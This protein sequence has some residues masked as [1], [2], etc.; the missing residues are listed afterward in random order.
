[1]SGQRG[2]PAGKRPEPRA[3]KKSGQPRR[4]GARNPVRPD[5]PAPPRN[6]DASSRGAGPFH[7][8]LANYVAFAAG[9]VAIVAGYVQL[10]AGSVTAAPFLLILGYAVLLPL[11]LILGWGKLDGE[12]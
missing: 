5:R 10:D 11:G 9:L 4:G 1:M 6:R 2:K 8:G 12:R 7:F 3:K